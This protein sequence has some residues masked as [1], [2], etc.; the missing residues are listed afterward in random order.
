MLRLYFSFVGVSIKS[1]MQHRASFFMLLIAYFLSTFV[2]ILGI[3]ILFDRFKMIQGWTLEELAL[4][5]S[6][7][8][9]GFSISEAALRGFD[10]FSL[11]IKE[12]GLIGCC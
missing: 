9:M 2:D 8:Q 7:M 5:Y 6:I 10:T 1:Q 11:M 4:L 12:E 3:W